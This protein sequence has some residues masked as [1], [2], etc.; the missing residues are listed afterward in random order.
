VVAGYEYATG[1]IDVLD[2]SALVAAG[3]VQVVPGR[4]V[5]DARPAAGAG[6]SGL[7]R[8]TGSTSPPAP[9]PSGIGTKPPQSHVSPGTS[10][11]HDDDQTDL[12]SD[13]TD[14]D[15]LPDMPT[16]PAKHILPRYQ[17]AAARTA[18][19]IYEDLG[20]KRSL[21]LVADQGGFT[22]QD[23][24]T[25]AREYHWEETYL[26]EQAEAARIA[27]S[28][29][30]PTQAIRL[31]ESLKASLQ[32]TLE[33]SISDPVKYGLKPAD[34]K[35]IF[36]MVKELTD[37]DM[38]RDQ[39]RPGKI[40]VLMDRE[41]YERANESRAQQIQEQKDDELYEKMHEQAMDIQKKNRSETR[42]ELRQDK[43]REEHAGT[44]PSGTK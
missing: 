26:Q 22:L 38:D 2:T 28:E 6:A 8:G 25:W 1:G 42:K 7:A 29:G 13:F 40:I 3:A 10:R 41:A 20:T 30:N 24:Q 37:T 12:L 31:R 9:A 17:E 15:A 43:E 33:L 39:M 44:I 21:E 23:V 35:A 16:Q 32:H 27:L 11:N 36:D 5:T 34:R 18:Y 4:T 14:I 19:Q